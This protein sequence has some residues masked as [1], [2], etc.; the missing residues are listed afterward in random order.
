M[1]K[2]A[3]VAAAEG[4]R[5]S[6]MA[7][8][9]PVAALLGP[10]LFGKSAGKAEEKTTTEA[11]AGKTF[12]GLYF[13]AKWCGPC[14]KFTPALAEAYAERTAKDEIEIVFVS[15]DSDVESFWLYFE[16]MP[17]LALPFEDRELAEDISA[18]F[19]IKGVPTLVILETA[20]G[21]VVTSDGR[22]AVEAAKKLCGV[23]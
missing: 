19:G 16:E 1:F 12:V 9:S 2:Q 5:R 23:F 7:S 22:S 4:E 10:C 8:A 20:T 17:W 13:S 14:R 21:R 18:K 6:G 3:K 11:L 15:S